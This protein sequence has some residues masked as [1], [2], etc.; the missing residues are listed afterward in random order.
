VDYGAKSPRDDWRLLNEVIS[1][2]CI[3]KHTIGPKVD[4]VYVS[5]RFFAG[6]YEMFCPKCRTEYRKGFYTC[7]DCEVSLVNELPPT[8]PNN[9]EV[10][11]ES[12]EYIPQNVIPSGFI[13]LTTFNSNV[14]AILAKGMLESEGIE[15]YVTSNDRG[16]VAG[17]LHAS[18]SG[19]AIYVDSKNAQQ[20]KELL[21]VSSEDHDDQSRSKKSVKDAKNLFTARVFIIMLS[22]FFFLLANLPM[23]PGKADEKNGLI[24]VAI[25]ILLA[26]FF[27]F[28]PK[29]T[30]HK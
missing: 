2:L 19:N 3:L 1:Q 8:L 21:K 14:E 5:G 15:V 12:V 13:L 9:S 30:K 16:A 7:A 26:L 23:K 29:G 27:T 28:T 11:G 4:D 22:A 18:L 17:T 10:K 25:L 6:D 24:S 20:A